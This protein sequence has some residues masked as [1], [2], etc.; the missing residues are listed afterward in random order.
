MNNFFLPIALVV[1][2]TGNA[3]AQTVVPAKNAGKHIGKTVKICDKVFGGRLLT[4]SNITLLD[5]GANSPNQ[6]LTIMIPSACRDKF[7]GRPEVD[8]RGKD[9]IVTGKLAVYNGKPEIV[10]TRPEQLKMVLI[11]NS[12]KR[13][14][15]VKQP[16]H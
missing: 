1:L 12:L 8:Y 14:V 9:V 7:K 5:I 16:I 6:E 10:I 13:A 2:F 3:S 11:D 4:P 15:P